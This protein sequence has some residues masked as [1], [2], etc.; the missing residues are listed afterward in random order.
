MQSFYNKKVVFTGVLDGKSRDEAA[1]IVRTKGADIDSGIICKTHFVIVG[2][3]A[4]P[5][6]LKKIEQYNAEGAGIMIIGQKEFLEM[7]KGDI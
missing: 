5:M 7:I 2:S 6:K 3:G 1:K 4:G